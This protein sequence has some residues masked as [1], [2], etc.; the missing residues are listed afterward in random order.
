MYTSD[1]VTTVTQSAMFPGMVGGLV[2]LDFHQKV[3]TTSR[4]SLGFTQSPVRWPS[5]FM[6]PKFERKG[7]DLEH[8]SLRNIRLRI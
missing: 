6:S 1:V 8:S 4:P 7:P 3:E 5:T 2:G